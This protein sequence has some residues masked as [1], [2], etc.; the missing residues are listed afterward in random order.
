MIAFAA[1]DQF[2]R[3]PDP[4]ART[5]DGSLQQVIRA[6]LPADL[7]L[8][9][10]RAFVPGHRGPGN[11]AEPVRREPSKLRNHL[12]RQTICEELLCRVFAEVLKRENS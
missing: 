4:I 8:T 11:H 12:S 5:S 9:L 1:L 10:R 7:V 2:G 6:Q 3:D